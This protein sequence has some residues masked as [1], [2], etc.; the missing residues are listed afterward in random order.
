MIKKVLI[1]FLAIV[2]LIAAAL[3]LCTTAKSEAYI[4]SETKEMEPTTIVTPSY[5]EPQTLDELNEILG[6]CENR[7]DNAHIMAEGA[8]AL[9][10]SNTD[11]VITEAKMHYQ[12]AKEDYNNYSTTYREKLEKDSFWEPK[13]QQYP[14]ATFIW[15]YYKNLGYNDYVLAGIFG[16]IMAEVGGQTLQINHMSRSNDGF[17]GMC[18]WSKSYRDVWNKELEDQCIFLQKTIRYEFDTY[19]YAYKSGFNYEK[20]CELTNEKEAA[21]A[22]AKCYERC[23]SASYKQRQKNATV[24]LNYFTK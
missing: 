7:M 12:K 24:A 17:Y 19:G 11:N 13:L 9:G 16:N 20:F 21:L 6:D 3:G 5:K 22:F 14:V 8:R 4:P 18:Q 23:A 15:L 2:T 1:A 10:Y